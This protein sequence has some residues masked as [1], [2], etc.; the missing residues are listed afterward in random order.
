VARQPVT[1]CIRFAHPMGRPLGAAQT[2]LC[3]S[4]KSNQKCRNLTAKLDHDGCISQC[5][6]SS[7]SRGLIAKRYRGYFFC[8]ALVSGFM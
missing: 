5:F 7:S 1:F 3:Y 8:A 2:T 6:L 4:K